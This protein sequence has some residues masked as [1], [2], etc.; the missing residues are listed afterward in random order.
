MDISN[1]T[2]EQKIS[3]AVAYLSKNIEEAPEPTRG[4]L[5]K[6]N[7]VNNEGMEIV[8]QIQAA[9]TQIE[10]LEVALSEKIGAAKVLFEVVGEQIPKEDV[11]ALAEKF[12]IKQ[13]A[14]PENAPVDMAGSTAKKG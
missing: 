10:Q 13:F 14:V 8:K 7:R 1:A 6:L 5:S 12:E 9:R 11:D 2:Q 3:A 4:S